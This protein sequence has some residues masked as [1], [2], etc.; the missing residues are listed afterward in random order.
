ML[1]FFHICFQQCLLC[2]KYN[3]SD[4]SLRQACRLYHRRDRPE[5]CSH[6][7]YGGLD[8]P[9]L[10]GETLY[11]FLNQTQPKLVVLETECYV[12]VNQL[13]RLLFYR[14]HRPED[15][16]TL[17]FWFTVFKLFLKRNRQYSRQHMGC[18]VIKWTT[19]DNMD[20]LEPYTSID[21]K[22]TSTFHFHLYPSN[23]EP[24]Y[25][26]RSQCFL[27]YLE[28]TVFKEEDPKHQWQKKVQEHLNKVSCTLDNTVEYARYIFTKEKQNLEN[29]NRNRNRNRIDNRIGDS[30]IVLGKRTKRPIDD[31]SNQKR[32]ARRSVSASMRV[33]CAARQQWHCIM[34]GNILDDTFQVDHIVPKKEGG[35][36]SMNNLQA[37]CAGCHGKKTRMEQIVVQV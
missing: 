5:G 26:V 25:F 6:C 10:S 9:V 34:C 35:I 18:N 17:N 30:V 8:V 20:P 32:K 21:P 27:E 15:V 23:V 16:A 36:C 12:C 22:S 7:H 3:P 37:L 14:S 31:V 33:S 2:P 13:V 19:D 29:R 24:M 4:K 28:G 11:R 1:H